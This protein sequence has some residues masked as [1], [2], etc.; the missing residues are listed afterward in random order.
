[1]KVVQFA[2]MKAGSR[3][4]VIARYADA[5]TFYVFLYDGTGGLRLL[6]NGDV[7]DNHTGTCGKVDANLTAGSWHTLKLSVSGSPSVR[8]QT[9]LD[10]API[11]D[12]TSTAVAPAAGSAGMYVY[13]SNT[14]VE[15]DDVKVSTP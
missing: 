14:I 7:P 2:N 4:G 12:C 1:M 3:G 8:L 10:G 9:F 11:H 6:M 15:F 5:S 13:G